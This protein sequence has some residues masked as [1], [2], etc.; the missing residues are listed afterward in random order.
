ML[1]AGARDSDRDWQSWY[2][3]VAYLEE[4]LYL[5]NIDLIHSINIFTPKFFSDENLQTSNFST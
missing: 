5:H 2:D 4:K 1:T 3:K